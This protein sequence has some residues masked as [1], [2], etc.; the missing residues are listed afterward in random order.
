MDIRMTLTG[1]NLGTIPPRGGGAPSNLPGI[2]IRTYADET[3]QPNDMSQG[4]LRAAGPVKFMPVVV[5]Y[6]VNEWSPTIFG[7]LTKNEQLT[8][9]LFEFCS[10]DL[11]GAAAKFYEVRLGVALLMGVRHFS[12]TDPAARA[13]TEELSLAFQ[14]IEQ[15]HFPS[16]NVG[17]TSVQ[18]VVPVAQVANIP[19][20]PDLQPAVSTVPH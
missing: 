19:A 18:S 1:T 10:P 12:P 20:R 6:D 7:A 8:T 15:T 17:A 3:Q 9:A 14:T 11:K 4:L 5:T 16:G 13:L 2:I